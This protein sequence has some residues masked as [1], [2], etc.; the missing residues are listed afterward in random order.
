MSWAN[1]GNLTSSLLVYVLFINFSCLIILAKISSTTLNKSVKSEHLHLIPDLR[2]AFSFPSLSMMLVVVCN[3]WPMCWGS[4][5]LYQFVQISSC[6]NVES[7]LLRWSY[8]FLSF[9]LVMC[10]IIFINLCILNYSCIPG[11]NPTLLWLIIFYTL[12]N[13]IC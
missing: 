1:K 12:L 5:L 6:K 2:R 4:I 7:Y 3:I 11:I 9:I 13:L 10:G 8:S